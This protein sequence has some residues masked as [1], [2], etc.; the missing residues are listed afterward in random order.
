[1]GILAD[2]I[3]TARSASGKKH[4]VQRRE[5]SLHGGTLSFRTTQTDYG[6]KCGCSAPAE[7]VIRKFVK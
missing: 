7:S 6:H 3:G 1:M 2:L 5:A 4:G